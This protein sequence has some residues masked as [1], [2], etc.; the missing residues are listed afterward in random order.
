MIIC[1]E[2][3]YFWSAVVVEIDTADLFHAGC[4]DQGSLR[5]Q[6]GNGGF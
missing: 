2:L 1:L 3:Q 6:Q 5:D 4:P